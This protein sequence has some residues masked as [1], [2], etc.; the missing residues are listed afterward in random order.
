MRIGLSK[1]DRRVLDSHQWDR[2]W[3]GTGAK[4]TTVKKLGDQPKATSHVRSVKLNPSVTIISHFRGPMKKVATPTGVLM[5]VFPVVDA[6][7][8]E[9]LSCKAFGKVAEALLRKTSIKAGVVLEMN[10]Q[11]NLYRGRLEFV[12]ESSFVY[13]APAPGNATSNPI[14]PTPQPKSEDVQCGHNGE[15]EDQSISSAQNGSRELG[16]ESSPDPLYQC[17]PNCS[18]D[19]TRVDSDDPNAPAIE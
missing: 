16:P 14:V 3:P 11:F 8:K 1:K 12:T 19:E 7:T 18:P 9:E 15:S 6:K 17:C 10:G 4:P 2:S 5:I 13:A